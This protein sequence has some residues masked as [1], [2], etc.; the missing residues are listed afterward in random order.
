M[1]SLSFHYIKPLNLYPT[2]FTLKLMKKLLPI[3]I[4]FLITNYSFAF[5]PACDPCGFCVGGTKPANWDQCVACLAQEGK[6]WTVLGC[7]PSNPGGFIQIILQT[8]VKIAGGIAFL[9]LLYGGFVLLT[10]GGDI[11]KITRGKTIVTSSIVGLLM[12]IF[13]VFILRLVGYE[14]LRIPGFGE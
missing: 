5:T 8:A 4:F 10:S 3:L 9:S 11:T 7:I 6:S 12:I 1:T 2:L 14:I 13:S